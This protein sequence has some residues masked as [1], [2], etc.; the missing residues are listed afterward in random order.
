MPARFAAVCITEAGGAA[1]DLLVVAGSTGV[2]DGCNQ[3]RMVIVDRAARGVSLSPMPP[4]AFV[5]E[6]PHSIARFDAVRVDPAQVM[7][8]DGYT[9]VIKPFRTIEDIH[10]VG[11]VL[12]CSG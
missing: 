2:V 9:T 6:I 1:A 3:I 4:V 7:P 11:A 5:Q 10:V 12:G 8:G